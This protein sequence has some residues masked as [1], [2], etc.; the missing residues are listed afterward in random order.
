[1]E[2]HRNEMTGETGDPRENPP[3]K[4][5]VQHDYH[6]RKS[7]VT[8]SGI[9]PGG[10][11]ACWSAAE[12]AK[13][14]AVN[15]TQS[16]AVVRWWISDVNAACQTEQMRLC[17]Q[18]NDTQAGTP[19]CSSWTMDQSESS[20]AL[21]LVDLAACT[22]YRVT[23]G[24]KTALSD[25]HQDVTFT[26]PLYGQS[27]A[28]FEFG[29]MSPRSPTLYYV[30]LKACDFKWS[31]VGELRRGKVGHGVGWG[32][33]KYP[34]AKSNGLGNPPPDSASND[35]R[36]DF[37]CKIHRGQAFYRLRCPAG[38]AIDAAV[39]NVSNTEAVVTWSFDTDKWDC[40]PDRMQVCH[41]PA[42][43]NSSAACN[44]LSSAVSRV[45]IRHLT[46]CTNYKVSLKLVTNVSPKP[47]RTF[48]ILTSSKGY[49]VLNHINLTT[50]DTTV[51]VD[52]VSVNTSLQCVRLY[53]VSWYSSHDARKTWRTFPVG[54][55][56]FT[57]FAVSRGQSYY[58]EVAAIFVD[59][60]TESLF[61]H[62][63]I[64]THS[65]T[66]HPDPV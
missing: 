23:V 47:T 52:W 49:P 37:M 45:A 34:S 22:A 14:R 66:S 43:K 24:L 15:V 61:E 25:S 56:S 51:R 40:R 10:L 17:Y 46:M 53:N 19:D 3:T 62:V 65:G 32:G 21:Q 42:D 60:T 4:G 5:F 54:T 1:M 7:G 48:Y 20:D 64:P 28:V 41:A 29:A 9:E 16:S 2:Q 30:F 12:V 6:M 35:G 36:G 57:I 55:A 58:V 33:E 13:V 11:Y 31:G 50:V 26:T 59:G 44:S 18:E 39:M 63:D 27:A 8:R 38:E